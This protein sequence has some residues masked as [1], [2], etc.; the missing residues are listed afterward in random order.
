M[1]E[2]LQ[3]IVTGGSRGIGFAAA[4]SFAQR[5]ASL[6]LIARDAEELARAKAELAN[7]P[8]SIAARTCD[9]SDA[10][11]VEGLTSFLENEFNG[12]V[13]VLVNAAGI[14]GPMGPLEETDPNAWKQ[15]FAVNVFGTMQMCRLV[16]PFMKRGKRGRIINFSGG[17]EG[18]FPRFTAYASSKGAIL[19]F[20]ESLAEEVRKDGMTVNAIAPGAVNTALVEEVLAAGEERVGSAFYQKS[21]AQK[22]SGGVSPEKA[23]AL[24][25][26]LCSEK[27]DKITGKMLSAV[28]D[29][30]GILER[31]VEDIAASDVYAS[32]RIKPKDR[33]YDW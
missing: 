3:V 28:H 17:G 27:A 25:T 1:N 16:L 20:T 15:T 4:R 6:L 7:L 12:R 9:V 18:P 14:Y 33:G 11:S 23:A 19:R 30:L 29:N 22:E 32:R 8:S 31:H 13:D 10:A 5:G 21:R 26:F 24:I 2:P